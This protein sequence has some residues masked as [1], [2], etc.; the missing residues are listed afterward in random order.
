MSS[1][2]VQRLQER[3]RKT[4]QFSPCNRRR[5]RLPGLRGQQT[6]PAAQ[7]S[8]LATARST[9]ATTELQQVSFGSNQPL[10]TRLG[11]LS[12]LP[13]PG[14][15]LSVLRNSVRRNSTSVRGISSQAESFM[16]LQGHSLEERSQPIQVH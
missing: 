10:Q 12:V 3:V 7:V 5:R 8:S 2:R 11:S 1:P 6:H 4:V 13:L 14:M 15:D 9:S 16:Q